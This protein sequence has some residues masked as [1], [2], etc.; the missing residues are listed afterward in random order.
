M[1]FKRT[2]YMSFDVVMLSSAHPATDDRIF[3]REARTLVESGYSVAVVGRHSRSE[4]VDGVAIR[5]LPVAANR[6]QRI[7]LGRTVLTIARELDAR[8]YIIHDPELIPVALLLRLLGKHVTYDAHE[9]LPA[10]VMQ[11]TWLPRVSR[12]VLSPVLAAIEWIASWLLNG[13]IAAVPA[14][15]IRFPVSRTEL[16]RNFPTPSALATLQEGLPLTERANIVIYTG[17]LSVIRGIRELVEAFREIEDAELWLVG[18]FDDENF[19]REI[20]SSLPHNVV[21]LGWR[22][23]LEV[24]RLYRL[25]KLGAVL[26]HSTANHRCALP[27]KLFEYMGAGLPVIASNFPQYTD[28]VSGCGVQVNP[29]DITEIRNTVR[30]L[31][32]D[33][34]WLR[35]MSARARERV[36]TSYSW[37]QEGRRFVQ[38]CE[39]RMSQRR[40]VSM[41][42]LATRL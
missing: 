40:D 39:K 36:V 27:V 20:L 30:T 35:D 5:A 42:V 3:Y 12:W 9:N 31:L 2:L 21:W 8:L 24:L 7:F 11:K 16:V 4:I 14:I 25:A 28:F 19:R 15:Q 38:F 33:S 41:S 26:L 13:V 10:Q 22:P 32:A 37:E 23:H 34:A 17:G 29:L 18:N 6:L 1:M